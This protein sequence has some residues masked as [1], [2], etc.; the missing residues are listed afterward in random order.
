MI[1]LLIGLTYVI[2]VL[3]LALGVA[4]LVIAARAGANHGRRPGS[5]KRSPL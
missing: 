3:G 5:S 2:Q 4:G 1:H